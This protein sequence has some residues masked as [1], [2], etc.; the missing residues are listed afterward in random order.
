MQANCK[1]LQNPTNLGCKR[2]K[3]QLVCIKKFV[4]NNPELIFYSF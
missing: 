3:L 4:P 2:D 1:Y